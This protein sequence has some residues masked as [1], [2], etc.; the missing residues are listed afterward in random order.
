[1]VRRK[2]RKTVRVDEKACRS[3]GPPSHPLLLLGLGPVTPP[4]S[5]VLLGCSL[6]RATP[7][8]NPSSEDNSQDGS[9]K[10]VLG[11]S[12]HN[13][14]VLK[15]ANGPGLILNAPSVSWGLSSPVCH[16]VFVYT[17]TPGPPRSL[18][19]AALGR[20]FPVNDECVMLASGSV[21][22]LFVFRNLS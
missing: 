17:S 13:S 1:M 21:F 4:P 6:V 2:G 18:T 12:P 22:C 11:T 10:P 20:Y 16:L 5:Q 15:L 7:K 8:P 14:Y 19:H 9:Q 3:W